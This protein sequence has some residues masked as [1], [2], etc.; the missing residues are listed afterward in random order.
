MEHLTALRTLQAAID[1]YPRLVALTFALNI[2]TRDSEMLQSRFQA[3]FRPLFDTLI[4]DRI[5]AGKTTPPTQLRFIW[6]LVKSVPHGVLL[7]NQSSIWQTGKDGELSDAVN[8]MLSCLHKAGEVVTGNECVEVSDPSY[9]Q[10]DRTD[11]ESFRYRHSLLEQSIS[12]LIR[13]SAE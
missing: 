8:S 6:F 11:A 9:L 13:E 1:Q 12:R 5:E 7:L 10:M 3:A 2:Q 4:N